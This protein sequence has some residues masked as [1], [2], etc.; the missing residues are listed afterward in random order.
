MSAIA[1]RARRRCSAASPPSRRWAAGIGWTEGD[2]GHGPAYQFRD[3]DDHVFE[4]YYETRR[5]EPPAEQKPALKNQ[6]QR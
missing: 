6:A 3:P 4:I 5:Y 2:L 1:R